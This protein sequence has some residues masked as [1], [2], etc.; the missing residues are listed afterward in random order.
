MLQ[1]SPWPLTAEAVRFLVPGFK[2]EALSNHPLTAPLYP[3]AFGYYPSAHGHAMRRDHHE[4]NL[5][6]YCRSGSGRVDVGEGWQPLQAGQLLVLPRGTAHC[7][8]SDHDDPWTI[9]WVHYEGHATADHHQHWGIRGPA[10]LEVGNS[11]LL[12]QQFS[13]LL[14]SRNTGY[15]LPALIQACAGLAY[16]FTTFARELANQS[17][18]NRPGRDTESAGLAK[19]REYMETHLTGPVSL[20]ELATLAGLSRWHFTR[21]YRDAYGYS[22]IQHF[23]HRKMEA[24]CELLDTR[25]LSITEVAYRMG[26][27]DPAYFSRLFRRITGMSP[28]AY[29]RS[30]RS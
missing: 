19:A 17:L 9:W 28:Q 3:H 13:A 2:I 18:R 24:A 16:L 14:A 8:E 15:Q 22:P 20:D 27:D 12:M 10:I 11:P 1:T 6:I 5:V 21:A 25:R 7:Y 26:Y 30:L 4:D 29:Q 23:I